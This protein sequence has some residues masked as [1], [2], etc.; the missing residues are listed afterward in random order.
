MVPGKLVGRGKAPVSTSFVVVALIG[1]L[2]LLMWF[3]EGRS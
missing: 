1:L 2:N 3:A